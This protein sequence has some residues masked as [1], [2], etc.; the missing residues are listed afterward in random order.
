MCVQM[1]VCVPAYVGW[2]GETGE[3]QAKRPC[4]TEESRTKLGE[5]KDLSDLVTYCLGH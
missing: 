3:G 5:A 4:R 2:A 1:G